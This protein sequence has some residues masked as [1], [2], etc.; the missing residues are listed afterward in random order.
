MSAYDTAIRL[1]NSLSSAEKRYFTVFSGKQQGEKEYLVLFKI[2]EKNDSRD[3]EKKHLSALF[4]QSCPHSSLDNAARYLV[5]IITDSLIHAKAEKDNLF[6][7]LWGLMRVKV[8]QER[9]LAE[10]GYKELK[11]IRQQAE[12]SQHHLLRYLTFRYELN[13]LSAVNFPG[14]SDTH[15]VE[16]QMKAKESLRTIHHIEEHYSLYELLKHRLIYSGRVESEA[17]KKKLNDLV[18]SEMGLV[19][20]K[21]KNNFESRKLHLLFQSFFFSDIGDHRSALKTFHELNKHFEENSNMQ[22]VPPMDY[23]SSLDG[24]LDSLRTAGNYQQMPF[25]IEKIRCMDSTPCPDY[26]RYLLLKTI[27]IYT[28]V[29]YIGTGKLTEASDFVLSLDP[30][31]LKAYPLIY[32]EKQCELY[33]YCAL[34]CFLKKDYKKAH[35]FIKEINSEN[36]RFAGIPVYKALRL[37]DIIIHYELRDSLFLGY[38]IRSY[39]RT[40]PQ[41]TKLMKCEKLVFKT[42]QLNP[43]SNTTHRNRSLAPKVNGYAQKIVN[44]KFE[45]QLL[46]Y[47][48]FVSWSTAKFQQGK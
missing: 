26:F 13:H 35:R 37:L 33:F 9:S 47:F 38:E 8:L 23:F 11:K 34:A 46:K 20:G 31:L 25:Y 27:T 15:L 3:I 45:K 10:E 22:E 28:L 40:F 16:M 5:K 2:I 43:F 32:D 44:D 7:I 41:R 17:D 24:V 21:V 12:A 1:V 4:R 29:L 6:S 42:I 18:L 19:T 14:V 30:L 48:D 36:L 39:K